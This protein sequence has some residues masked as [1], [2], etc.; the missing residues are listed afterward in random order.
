MKKKVLFL[1][2]GNSCRSQMAEGWANS[3]MGD[4][5]TASSAGITTHGLNPQ[6]VEVMAEKGVDISSHQ[7]KNIDTLNDTFDLVV[8]VCDN[9]H[10]TC[11]ILP[12][13]W[14]QEHHSFPDPPSQA[15]ILAEQGAS[16]QQQL[17]CYRQVRDLIKEFVQKDLLNILKRR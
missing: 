8:T 5:L 14:R 9:A 15:K 3:L 2:T 13:N 1:C 11:P 7:S 10:E 16:S 4:M 12:A 6:A 17:D